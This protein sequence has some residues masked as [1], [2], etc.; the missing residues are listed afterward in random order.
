MSRQLFHK[1]TDLESF[2]VDVMKLVEHLTIGTQWP[3]GQWRVTAHL[4][5]SVKHRSP[6][7][8]YYLFMHNNEFSN[9]H[10]MLTVFFSDNIAYGDCSRT[11]P[12]AEITEAAR[13]ANIHNFIQSLPLVSL[14][15]IW[16][17]TQLKYQ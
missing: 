11:I 3:N 12:M 9:V 16:L 10:Y 2:V 13:N 8:S 5:A 1:R 17:T 6:V 15:I 7:L 14:C 4:K